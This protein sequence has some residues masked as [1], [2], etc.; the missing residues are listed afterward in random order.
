MERARVLV[1]DDDADIREL[2]SDALTQWGYDV[3]A[4]GSGR[5]AVARITRELFDAAL[6]DIWM[7][8]VD[9]LQLLDEIKRHNAAIDV[10]MMT[11]DPMV[12][13]AVQALKSGAYDYLVKPLNLDELRHL[14]RRV[15]EKRFL[16]REVSTL[17]TKLGEHLAEKE[18]V[19]ASPQM[20]RVKE[21]VARVAESDSPVLVEGESGTGKELVAS[22]IHRRSARAK[23]P[24]VPVNCGAIPAELMESE[25]FGHVKGAFTG[26]VADALGLFRSANGGTLFLDEVAELPQA[27]QA[28][29]LRVLEAK[30]IRPVGTTKTLAVD[31]RIIAATNK[32]LE[33]A[34]K[35]G[36]FR[37]DLYYRLNVVRIALPPLRERKAEIPALVTHFL[38]QLNERFCRDVRG[39]AP[40]A[41]AAL[42][43]YDFPGNVRELENIF[44][45]AYAL[46][47]HHEITLADLP[48]LA[49]TGMPAAPATGESLPTL[50]QAERDLIAASLRRYGK[51]KEKAARALGLTVR[52]FY[53][54][55][56]KFGLS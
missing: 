27:L 16:T 52:T 48:D 14:M 2:L 31:V 41:L 46:G 7:P 35:S 53:R 9:G 21:L 40:D 19:G 22:A 34:I 54:R 15:L 37:Q 45:R 28:K 56:K 39:I 17:R 43:A 12:S 24:L 50:D 18:L 4:V 51:D 10:V 20:A 29:L 25:F 26:A 36:S 33:E 30:E 44:E 32:D 55:L 3:I 47:A 11:G 38:R 8:G 42:Q 6:V 23:R 49:S 5:E 1:A 13:T